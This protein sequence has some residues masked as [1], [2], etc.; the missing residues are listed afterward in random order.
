MISSFFNRAKP[1]NFLLISLYL[2]FFYWITQIYL[3]DTGWTV[4]VFFSY[5][6]VFL[7]IVFSVFLANFIIRKNALCTGN[8]YA[9]LLFVM[10]LTLFPQIFRSSEIIMANLF[11]LLAL[12]RVISIRSLLQIKQKIFDA[13][14]WVC[15]AALFYEWALLFLLVV[16]AA[17]LIYRF[18][19][20][21]NWLVPLV[22]IFTVGVLLSTYVIWFTGIDWF[23]DVFSFSV[24]FYSIKTR[25]I[26]F[27]LPVAL[28]AFFTLLSLAAFIANY[29]AKST[30]VQSSL[31]L[32][33]IALLVGTGIAAVS[34]NRESDEVVF[35]F[36]PAAVLMANYLQLITRK[37]WKESILWLFIILPVAL[38]FIGQT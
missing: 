37:W 28:I 9:V 31:L 27:I 35:T 3:Y 33:I 1:I 17:I 25:T 6:G 22:A 24:D 5:A 34:N 36:F 15:V 18:G 8:S 4:P 13:S 38:L 7:A 21:R 11:V 10:F 19:D 29:K 26:G 12:R 14:L 23:V 30:G 20:Y 16:F 32:V 2:G